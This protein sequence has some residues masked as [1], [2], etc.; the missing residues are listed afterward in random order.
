MT[1]SVIIP[2]YND[3]KALLTT[4]KSIKLQRTQPDEI[5]ISDDGSTVSINEVIDFAKT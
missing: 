4:L 5:V 1:F 2:F 3:I